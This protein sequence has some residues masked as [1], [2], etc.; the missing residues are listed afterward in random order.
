MNTTEIVKWGLIAGAAWYLIDRLQKGQSLLPGIIPEPQQPA[1]PA[2]QQP[3]QTSDFRA[4]LAQAAGTT[5]G[6]NFDQWNYYAQ[7]L[8][9][10]LWPG[11]E[12]VGL[13][14]VD[15]M[16]PMTI[17]QWIEAH[18]GKQQGVNGLGPLYQ[19]ITVRDQG[20]MM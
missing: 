20:R 6:L 3:N 2:P 12:D 5:T 8:T 10:K 18:Q 1:L 14:R 19:A 11:P 17:D 16:P 9:G 7:Q 13:S 4:Q 15:P